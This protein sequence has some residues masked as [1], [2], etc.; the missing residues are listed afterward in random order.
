MLFKSIIC[1]SIEWSFP[2]SRLGKVALI[3]DTKSQNFILSLVRDIEDG[4]RRTFIAVLPAIV[5]EIEIFGFK[6]IDPLAQLIESE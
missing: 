6:L 2:S 3:K 4:I 5:T 1:S